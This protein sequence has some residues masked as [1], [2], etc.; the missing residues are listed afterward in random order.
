MTATTIGA[1]RA[2]PAADRNAFLFLVAL[3][4]VGVLTG[5]GTDSFDHVRKHGLD[6]P[7]IVH[8][9]AVAFV[10]WLVLFTTQVL[11][12]RNGRYDLHR[13]LGLAAIGLACAMVVLGPAT[14]L[15]MDAARYVAKGETPEFLAVQFTDILAFATLAGAGIAL[16]GTPAAHKRLMLLAL[17][18]ISDAGF[19]RFLNNFAATPLG[20]GFWGEMAGLY[21]GSDL[22]ALGLGA[23]DVVT[24]RRL[25]PA[26]VAGVAWMITLELTAQHL[27]HSSCWKALTLHM[28]GH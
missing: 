18:Y 11:L 28:I 20:D 3:I 25:H 1:F 27:L 26:Y 22:V 7:L 24:R 21:L 12:I 5:F 14:A 6:Y 23:Y 13:R 19:S 4:W 16:R 10:G 8:F 2:K 9:H 15:T 17:C